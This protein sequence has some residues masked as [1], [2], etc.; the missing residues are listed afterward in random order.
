MRHFPCLPCI[1]KC[2]SVLEHS[3]F[4][5]FF[6]IF[7][8]KFYLKKFWTELGRPSP[9]QAVAQPSRAA[10]PRPRDGLSTEH[11]PP[12]PPPV[13]APDSRRRLYLAPPP[14]K[15]HLAPRLYKPRPC[16]LF[17]SSVAA[18]ASPATAATLRSHRSPPTPSPHSAPPRLAGA[19]A[20]SPEPPVFFGLGKN[21][22]V[23]I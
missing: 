18:A 20:S 19:A 3:S 15:P 7:G 16:R 22:P 14:C 5:L 11:E 17:S 9:S 1:I 23:F 2:F 6:C 12:L 13:S 8:K 10:R 4:F 21:R